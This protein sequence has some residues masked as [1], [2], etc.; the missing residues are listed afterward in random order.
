MLWEDDIAAAGDGYLEAIV[1][2]AAQH[3]SVPIAIQVDHATTL[4]SCLRC[5][6]NGHT[7]VMIDASHL[8]FEANVAL[9]KQVVDICHLLDVMVEGEIGTIPR[10]FENTG[11][12]A[13]TKRLTDPDEAAEFVR[14]TGLDA[15][16]V[17]I[18]TESGL[19]KEPP[20]LDFDRLRAIQRKTEAFLVLHGGSGTPADQIRQ[21]VQDGIVG[22][23]YA[24]E[25][26]IA[27]YNTLEAKRREL[28]H[29]FPDSRKILGPAREAAK[30]IIKDK[31]HQ[32][33]SVGQACTDGLCPPVL[34]T[35]GP[36]RAASDPPANVE[37][38]VAAVLEHLR[39][40]QG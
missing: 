4:Q 34:Q 2:H 8:P 12:F 29:D 18:G 30:A 37:E 36:A 21:A 9:T 25:I 26:R 13:E 27:F 7:S 1:K 14:Q 16:A 10:T 5:V 3:T 35:R 17:S 39:G 31:L 6:M 38:I 20:Q 28:G 19:Y 24:T 40:R 11:R 15:L 22:V 32:M 33:G 23:R